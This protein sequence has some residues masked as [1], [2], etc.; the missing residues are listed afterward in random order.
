MDL[1]PA[2]LGTSQLALPG[3]AAVALAAALLYAI[4]FDQGAL[5]APVT[6]ALAD[7]GGILHAVFHDARHLLG[8]PCH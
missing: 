8:V 6:D 2:P 7:E 4:G 5:V 1:H 3:L